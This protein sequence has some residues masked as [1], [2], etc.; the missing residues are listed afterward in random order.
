LVKTGGMDI[1]QAIMPLPYKEPSQALMALV[2][3]IAQ[4]GMRIGG[5]SEQQV[6]EGRADAPVGTTL[7]MIEQATKVLDS[8]HKRMHSSQSAEFAL[9]RDC[10]KDHPESFWQRKNKSAVKWDEDTFL[11]AIQDVEFAPQADPNTASHGQRMMKIMALKQLQ[12]ANPTLY[13]PNAIDTAALQALGWS[14]PQQFFAPPAAQAA[15]PPQIQE[16]M[17]K[18]ATADK[19]ADAA[20]VGAQAKAAETQAKIQQM[21]QQG[22]P[23]AP[24]LDPNKVLDVNAKLEEAHI[25][26]D[27]SF[28]EAENRKRDRESHERIAGLGFAEQMAQNPQG[29]PV[30]EKFIEGPLIHTLESDE[31]PLQLQP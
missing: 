13:D 22:Q 21:G 24:S 10:F 20:M 29:I 11:R 31:P 7:A 15:P 14:N 23:A 27:I 1:R 5:T 30:A 2:Q 16:A 6:G 4:T 28:I 3:D 18:Q 25:Q 19:K 8:V 17:A 9:L 12:A 26:K